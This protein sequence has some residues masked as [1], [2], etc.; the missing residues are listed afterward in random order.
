MYVVFTSLV[1]FVEIFLIVIFLLFFL[2]VYCIEFF[3]ILFVGKVDVCCF[4]KI[5][6]LISDNFI[7]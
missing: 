4:D 3:R 7:V 5:G 6:I 2:G 1:F